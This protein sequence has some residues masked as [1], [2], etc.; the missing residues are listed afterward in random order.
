MG[1]ESGGILWSGSLTSYNYGFGWAAAVSRSAGDGSAFK[2]LR[3]YWQDPPDSLCCWSEPSVPCSRA[4]LQGSYMAAVVHHGEGVR[5]REKGNK[6]E[7]G[8]TA[9]HFC[10]IH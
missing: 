7:V 5:K 4:A 10:Q 8:G 2:L 1:Q 6:T 3:W 9:H